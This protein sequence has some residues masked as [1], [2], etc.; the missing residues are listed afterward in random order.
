MNNK[1]VNI[2]NNL[3]GIIADKGLKFTINTFENENLVLSTEF[4]PI[5]KFSI[6]DMIGSL[7]TVQQITCVEVKSDQTGFIHLILQKKATPEVLKMEIIE[8]LKNV[9]V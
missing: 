1:Q 5:K 9:I 6:V 7:P 8:M 2:M 4:N 3:P